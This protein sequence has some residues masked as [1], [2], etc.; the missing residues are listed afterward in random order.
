M[1]II[2]FIFKI[3]FI[4]LEVDYQDCQT[5]PLSTDPFSLLK[6]NFNFW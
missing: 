6:D 1:S 2:F 4:Y 3:L 5:N